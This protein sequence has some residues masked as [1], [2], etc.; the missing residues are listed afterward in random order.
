MS[1]SHTLRAAA[2]ATALALTSTFSLRAAEAA[3]TEDEDASAT[4]VKRTSGQILKMGTRVAAAEIARATGKPV[5]TTPDSA[6]RKIKRL[7]SA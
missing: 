6:V 1:R 2:L 5:L 4:S 3:A 7:L